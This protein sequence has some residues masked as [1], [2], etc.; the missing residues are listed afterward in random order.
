MNNNCWEILGCS[1]KECP[2]HGKT[3]EKCWLVGGTFCNDGINSGECVEKMAS[4][5]DCEVFK[6]NYDQSD[7]LKTLDVMSGQ[8]R[9]VTEKLQ[10][11]KE[12]LKSAQKKLSEFKT[13]SVYLLKELDKKN[14]EITEAVRNR[15]AELREAESRLSQAAKVAALSRFSAGIAHEINNPLGAVINYLRTALADPELK[16]DAR[17]YLEQSLKG[18]FR[19][20]NVVKQI[21]SYSGRQNLEPVDIN[22]LLVE[23]AEFNRFRLKEKS[24]KLTLDLAPSL[25]KTYADPSQLSQVF[26]NI[27]K[28]SSDAMEKTERKEALI[29]TSLGENGIITVFKDSGKGISPEHKDKLFTPFFTTKEVGE[30]TG[31]GLFISYNI[32]QV[33]RGSMD[34]QNIPEGGTAVLI[35]LPVYKEKQ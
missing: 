28:N 9:S 1:K 10:A 19:I 5:I 14:K 24:I 25:P 18:L 11:E 17:N 2:A 8:F 32:I 15:T 33:L 16:T 31:L 35:T 4:C 21:L 7:C 23:L 12:E 30:G 26:M 6:T 22:K 20:D 27:L 3:D 29:S 34:I 13:T